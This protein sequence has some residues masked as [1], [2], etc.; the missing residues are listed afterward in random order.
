MISS[1]EYEDWKFL[2]IICRYS[3]TVGVAEEV[4]PHLGRSSIFPLVVWKFFDTT[5]TLLYSMYSKGYVYISNGDG[6]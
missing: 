4:V 5:I 2:W 3:L 1:I 6:F